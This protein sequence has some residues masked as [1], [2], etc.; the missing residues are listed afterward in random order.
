MKRVMIFPPAA[1]FALRQHP[2]ALVLIPEEKGLWIPQHTE[3]PILIPQEQ[4]LW[5]PFGLSSIAPLLSL[6]TK[7]LK[8]APYPVGA[9][10]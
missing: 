10:T 4:G 6:M 3:A 2:E 7:N 5:I 8:I 9:T 1:V